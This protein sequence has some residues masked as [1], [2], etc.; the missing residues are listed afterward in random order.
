VFPQR[1]IR[2]D[3]DEEKELGI[4]EQ[5]ALAPSACGFHY[6]SSSLTTFAALLRRGVE[7]SL[8]GDK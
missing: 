8:T 4:L 6:S 5:I 7:V 1:S 3:A 2:P